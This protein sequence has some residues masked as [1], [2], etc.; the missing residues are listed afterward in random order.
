MEKPKQEEGLPPH[1]MEAEEAVLGAVL[2]SP[3]ESRGVVR[4]LLEL[5]WNGPE[6]FYDLRIRT[7]WSKVGEIYDEGI[8]IDLIVLV[9]RLKRSGEL[10][11]VGGLAYMASLPDRCPS[12]SMAPHFARIVAEHAMSRNILKLSTLANERVN[13]GE[14]PIETL[15]WL[16][17]RYQG[18]A[19]RQI[20]SHSHHVGS[21]TAGAMDAICNPKA[22]HAGI[23]TGFETL[24]G[25]TLGFL[26][27]SYTIIA[28]RPSIGKTSLGVT[29]AA[30]MAD[31]GI[32]VAFVSL[33]MTA[34]QLVNR[35]L[36]MR[37]EVD[38][39]RIYKNSVTEE[40]KERLQISS[41]KLAGQPLYIDDTPDRNFER[42]CS[43]IRTL[44]AA[45]G[46]RI[47]FVDYLQLARLPDRRG[48]RR[49]EVTEI[50]AM[51]KSLSVEL[52]IPIVVLSQ[53]NRELEKGGK[54]RPPVISDLKESG[55]IEQD[56]DTIYL[57]WR[58]DE[59]NGTPPPVIKVE[60]IVAKQRNGPRTKIKLRFESA[61]TKFSEHPKLEEDDVP[62]GW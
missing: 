6:T 7:L 10:D 29:M 25:T 22:Q 57:L 56:A 61:F 40:E 23:G 41:E 54:A 26:P 13:G 5:L 21:L 60:L 58:P 44:H 62:P 45:K 49:D 46:I 55:D 38:S 4:Q 47:A 1:S 53:L 36:S 16:I 59:D 14:R 15:T 35:I 9:D 37:A 34:V 52:N 24:D 18:V 31:D 33:E 39:F 51:C 42:V 32:P 28:A 20:G 17:Q 2:I 27:G 3:G 48:N 12:A 8:Q 30:T 19:N 11:R 50:S 43:R